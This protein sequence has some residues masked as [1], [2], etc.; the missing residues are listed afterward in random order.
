MTQDYDRLKDLIIHNVLCYLKTKD[1]KLKHEAKEQLKSFSK[2]YNINIKK[3][4]KIGAYEAL[5]QFIKNDKGYN[6]TINK[7]ISSL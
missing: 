2:P 3:V 1:K 5:L 4:D 7:L 6:I